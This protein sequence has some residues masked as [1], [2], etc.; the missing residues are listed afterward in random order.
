MGLTLERN[1]TANFRRTCFLQIP[2]HSRLSPLGTEFWAELGEIY[3][4]SHKLIM[5][6]KGLKET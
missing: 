2:E 3:V 1:T 4:L 5:R 6:E